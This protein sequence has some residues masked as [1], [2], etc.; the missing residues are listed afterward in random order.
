MYRKKS[1]Q[2]VKGEILSLHPNMVDGI[3]RVYKAMYQLQT[4]CSKQMVE[5]L[6]DY[7]IEK[8]YNM[9]DIPMVCFRMIKNPDIALIA[10]K[11]K[12]GDVKYYFDITIS[13]EE[14][15]Y[16]E[17]P[18]TRDLFI[19]KI[20]NDPKNWYLPGVANQGESKVPNIVLCIKKTNEIDY[21]SMF[22]YNGEF[23]P[24]MWDLVETTEEE[25]CHAT[26]STE[27]LG[28]NIYDDEEHKV[29]HWTTKLKIRIFDLFDNKLEKYRNEDDPQ[30]R[31]DF[32]EFE[33]MTCKI[34][35][36][37]YRETFGN[38]LNC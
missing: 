16:L 34:F 37:V 25:K 7:Y 5:E 15:K 3:P 22:S 27:L 13:D 4:Y 14:E 38:I 12:S 23:T 6:I 24:I 21:S 35:K 9:Y 32:A 31:A 36:H 30:K 8:E 33:L 19:E 28:Y 1:L 29:K 2:S 10:E 11:M 18:T 26:I 20:Q 17:V